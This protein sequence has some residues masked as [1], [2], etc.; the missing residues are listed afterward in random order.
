MFQTRKR[1]KHH[2]L[3]CAGG[4]LVLALFMHTQTAQAQ[5]PLPL[6]EN[7]N[8]VV[9]HEDL[10]LLHDTGNSFCLNES[11]MSCVTCHGGDPKAVT[12]EA[13]HAFRDPHP[14]AGTEVIRCQVCHP[15]ECSERVWLF[16]QRA[17][18]GNLLVVPTYDVPS[19]GQAANSS[20][21]NAPAASVG[22]WQVLPLLI[23]ILVSISMGLWINKEY[24]PA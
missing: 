9:C 12:K 1:F 17:G 11:P 4:L 15:A 6:S 23:L 19:S 2:L 14:V 18:V 5:E 13:A 3:V 10:Y 8:C 7:S 21:L 24:H 16:D 20:N 22:F